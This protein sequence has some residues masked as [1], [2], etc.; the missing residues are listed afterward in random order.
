MKKLTFIVFIGAILIA[1]I[2][3]IDAQAQAQTVYDQ[4][5]TKFITEDIQY[6]TDLKIK[7]ERLAR[8]TLPQCNQDLIE[9]QR[10][11]PE[12]K[13]QPQF[14]KSQNSDDK[15]IVGPSRGQWIEKIDVDFCDDQIKVNLLA[16]AYDLNA[17]PSLLPLLNGNT[18]IVLYD[19]MEAEEQVK[20]TLKN[21]TQ[22]NAKAF[23]T[24]TQFL[25]YR[26]EKTGEPLTQIN[27]NR[28]WIEQW[29]VNACNQNFTVNLATLPD[30]E[31]QYK[32]IAQIAKAT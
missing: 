29:T 26:P 10:N 16:T 7:A 25:G 11:N 22:C 5:F 8:L 1:P 24:N 13:L 20:Q 30:P 32:Y 19:Q 9:I 6:N 12:I 23:I 4:A 3:N 18:K 14:I 2:S 27:N 15:D 28:G 21:S 31:T 17:R